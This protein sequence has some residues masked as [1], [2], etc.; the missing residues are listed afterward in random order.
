MYLNVIHSSPIIKVC[1]VVVFF[2][3]SLKLSVRCWLLYHIKGGKSDV[4]C[5]G[6]ILFIYLFLHHITC[7]LNTGV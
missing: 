1:W 6:L 3:F 7:D 4:I 2:F 5:L